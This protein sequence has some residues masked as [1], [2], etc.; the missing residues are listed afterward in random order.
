MTNEIAQTSFAKRTH[1]VEGKDKSRVL[2]FKN[3]QIIVTAL[4]K[5]TRWKQAGKGTLLR[6]PDG[7]DNRVIVEVLSE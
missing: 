2:Q 4:R 3:S 1:K 5:I 7:G 6:W